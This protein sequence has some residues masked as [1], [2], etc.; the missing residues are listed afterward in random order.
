MYLQYVQENYEL[1]NIQLYQNQD[2]ASV[3]MLE[4]YNAIVL[5]YYTVR[6]DRNIIK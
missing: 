5:Y 4:C 1:N 6:V 2:N 3:R